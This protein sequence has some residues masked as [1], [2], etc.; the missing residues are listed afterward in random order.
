[1]PSDEATSTWGLPVEPAST[2]IWAPVQADTLSWRIISQVRAALFAGQL[3]PG[4]FLGTEASLAAQFGV[5]RMAARDALRSLAAVGIITI[6][7]G[8]KGGAVIAQGNAEHFADALAVQLTLIG[9]TDTEMLDAQIGIEAMAAELAAHRAA[10]E[11]LTR[12]AGLLEELR[13][14][15]D[16]PV[17]FTDVSMRFHL[18]VVEASHNRAL[19][20]QFKALRH[21]L[22]PAY[23]RHTTREIAQRAI[24]AHAIL[25]KHIEAGD[26]DAARAQMV[27]R[28]K[29]IRNNRFSGDEIPTARH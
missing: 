16:E 9:V 11:D 20:A 29:V 25:L 15:L 23:T 3:K 14:L 28:L 26:A 18:A 2:P 5:S 17:S 10:P 12:M 1:M 19:V 13:R 4:D 22:Q 7:Q 24:E 21:V 6:R 8:A 27:K